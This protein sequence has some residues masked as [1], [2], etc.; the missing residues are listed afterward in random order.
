M[1]G[2]FVVVVKSFCKEMSSR[3]EKSATNQSGVPTQ[4]VVKQKQGNNKAEQGGGKGN[5]NQ[6]KQQG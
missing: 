1:K 5:N 2:K 3:K 6:K 4:G